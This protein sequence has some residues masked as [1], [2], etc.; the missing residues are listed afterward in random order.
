MQNGTGH[1]EKQFV[2]SNKVKDMTQQFYPS[3][4]S[5]EENFSSHKNLYMDIYSDFIHD[6]QELVSQS[7]CPSTGEWINYDTSIQWKTTQQW[8]EMNY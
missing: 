4:L 6:C 3:Y 8:K 5:K 7:K 2:V 1:F